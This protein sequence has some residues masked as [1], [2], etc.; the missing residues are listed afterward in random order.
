MSAC[1]L[2]QRESYDQPCGVEER[3]AFSRKN[4]EYIVRKQRCHGIQ[5]RKTKFNPSFREPG[6][7]RH[8]ASRPLVPTSFLGSCGLS[9]ASLR[10]SLLP[11][12]GSITQSLLPLT[13]TAP[14]PLGPDFN[15]L[16][17]KCGPAHCLG[18]PCKAQVT[19]CQWR[20][21]C[22]CEC[23]N[24]GQPAKGRSRL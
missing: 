13:L 17:D 14:R 18:K 22:G 2:S 11:S 3:Q 8:Q 10:V 19:R 15:F 24:P 9:P 6:E 1:L 7:H 16:V 5:G 20:C 4:E 23:S 12:P 21:H